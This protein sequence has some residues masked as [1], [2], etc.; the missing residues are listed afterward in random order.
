MEQK[1]NF[2]LIQSGNHVEVYRYL[3]K[4]IKIGFK[5]P[6]RRLRLGE[7]FTKK[8]TQQIKDALGQYD[9][10]DYKM[11]QGKH[12]VEDI[13][14][15]LFNYQQ[16]AKEEE[17][18][19]KRKA[20]SS[21][22]RTRNEMRRLINANTDLT[23]FLTLTFA[24]STPIVKT[25]N[26]QFNQFCKRMAKAFEVYKYI[27]VIEFQSDRDFH[28]KIKAE[29]G[30]VHYHVLCNFDIPA[31]MDKKTRFKL[32]RDFAVKHWR[33]GF[34]TIKEVEHVDNMGAYFCKYLSKDMF[35]ERMF[36]KKKYFCSQNLNRP[37]KL[38][39]D[40]AKAHF[41]MKIGDIKPDF[42]KEFNSKWIG[43]VGYGVYKISE[44]LAI[45]AKKA[46]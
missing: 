33:N 43:H 6:L 23:T 26:Y 20:K 18:E 16:L 42:E 31:K 46:L 28:G 25:A 19:R 3:D 5:R 1:Y 38:V 4:E 37:V 9:F 13:E 10:Y 21:L 35:D 27:A 15:N 12:L 34:V 40:E 8:E 11:A 32:E 17:E 14:L 36:K 45:S 2:K 30:S 29:R 24:K 41:K 7:K 39:G 44:A 22:S